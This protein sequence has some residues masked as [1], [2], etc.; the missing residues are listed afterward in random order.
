MLNTYDLFITR[1]IHGKLPIQI[2]LHKK[3]KSFVDITQI[4]CINGFQ[5]HEDF[6][7]KEELNEILNNYFNNFLQLKICQ[8]L[9]F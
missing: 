9:I 2:D 1:V 5:F 3:I 4:S 7:G 8:W 6:D